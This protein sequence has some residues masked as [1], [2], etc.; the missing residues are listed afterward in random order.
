MSYEL[1]L[2]K[3]LRVYLL[4]CISWT[5]NIK[6]SCFLPAIILSYFSFDFSNLS[7]NFKISHPQTLP[8]TL[9]YS[10]QHIQW[11]SLCGDSW[12]CDELF[13]LLRLKSSRRRGPLSPLPCIPKKSPGNW[14]ATAGF[15][16]PTELSWSLGIPVVPKW[17]FPSYL[18]WSGELMTFLTSSPMMYS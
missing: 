4:V 17:N 10:C 5:L 7:C 18:P 11:H 14:F 9:V 6:Y 8:E 3:S 16:I 1:V 12:L 13:T 15:L 2:I